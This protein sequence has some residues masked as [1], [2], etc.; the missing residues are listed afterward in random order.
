MLNLYSEYYSIH[1]ALPNFRQTKVQYLPIF[2]IEKWELL[3]IFSIANY[4][5]IYL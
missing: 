2:R 4:E 5:K 1:G 3:V